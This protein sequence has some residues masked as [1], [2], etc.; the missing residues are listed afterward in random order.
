M[1]RVR[2]PAV[3]MEGLCNPLQQG[4]TAIELMV[5][6]AILA[7]LASLAAPSFKPLIERWRVRQTVEGLQSTLYYARSEAIRRGGGIVVEKLPK[8]SNGCPLAA[9]NADWDCGWTVYVTAGHNGLLNGLELR[10]M[11]APASTTVTRSGAGTNAHRI[12][13]DRWGNLDG[14]TALEFVVAPHPTGNSSPATK[15]LCVAPGGRIRIIGQEQLP[16]SP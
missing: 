6:I 8:D 12:R 5:T 4:F 13:L 3:A 9:G 7:V 15:G 14:A 10:R 11:D 2:Q 1:S 16:C